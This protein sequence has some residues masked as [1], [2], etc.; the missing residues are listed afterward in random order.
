VKYS[1]AQVIKVFES[2]DGTA[3]V[4]LLGRNDG[5]YEYRAYVERYEGA[6]LLVGYLQIQNRTRG[7]KYEQHQ[8]E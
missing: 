6:A 1:H 8:S 4:E 7:V 3:R 5:F 2:S